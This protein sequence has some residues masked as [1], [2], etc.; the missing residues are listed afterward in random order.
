MTLVA[1]LAAECAG[2]NG[3]PRY[4][5]PPAAGAAMPTIRL[6]A[7]DNKLAQLR[8]WAEPRSDRYGIPERAL[9]AYGYATVVMAKAQP[10]CHLGW[11][12]LAGIAQVESNHAR[13]GGATI[14]TDGQVLPVIRG[15]PL[16][17][18]AGNEAIADPLSPGDGS[19]I[20]ARAMGP[21][22]FIPDTWGRWGIRADLDYDLLAVALE[23]QQPVATDDLS[24]DPDN[25][26]DAALAAGRCLCAAGGDLSTAEGWQRAIFA[27]N[28]SPVYVEQVRTA[29]LDYDA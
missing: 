9:E 23:D 26:D 3:N 13:F 15:V 25:I 21:F 5:A 2:G 22:Q 16:D 12:T 7:V 6:N 4:A 28:H 8:D 17:G 29:A 11:T 1:V 19:I 18:T 24:G 10:D 20:Y 27:Y 14:D